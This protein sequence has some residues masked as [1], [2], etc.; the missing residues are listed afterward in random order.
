MGT[1]GEA[2]SRNSIPAVVS[3]PAPQDSGSCAAYGA[4]IREVATV[5]RVGENQH[6][7]HDRHKSRK[8]L[9]TQRHSE[10]D[11]TQPRLCMAR[12]GELTP[13]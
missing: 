1:H 3:R 12:L 6:D 13:Q 7:V 9:T 11:S 2:W 8:A 4:N 5:R 10:L